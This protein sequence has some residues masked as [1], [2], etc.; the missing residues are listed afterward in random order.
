MERFCD[1]PSALHLLIVIEGEGRGV[2][3]SGVMMTYVM[4][5]LFWKRVE[6]RCS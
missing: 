2:E 3:S 6:V 1:E 5:H 4:N